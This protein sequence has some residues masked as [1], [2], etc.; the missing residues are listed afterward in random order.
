MLDEEMMTL[1]VGLELGKYWEKAQIQKGLILCKSCELGFK[2][3][4]TQEEV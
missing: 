4:N 1:V 3:G 2:F